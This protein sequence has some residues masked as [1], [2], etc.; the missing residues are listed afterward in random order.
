MPP[1][2]L[3]R[4][5]CEICGG[6]Q[7][8]NKDYLPEVGTLRPCC[9]HLK[10]P[11]SSVKLTEPTRKFWVGEACD[12]PPPPPGL[13]SSRPSISSS[14]ISHDFVDLRHTERGKGGCEEHFIQF[15]FFSLSLL[16]SGQRA[17]PHKIATRAKVSITDT[18]VCTATGKERAGMS[19]SQAE[20]GRGERAH[21]WPPTM[22]LH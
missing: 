6:P 14:Y 1:N 9:G 7:G 11:E 10:S 21:P 3:R 4:E 18:C 20:E 22:K 2:C 19:L 16:W 12:R 13:S 5:N 8:L 15:L 17:A